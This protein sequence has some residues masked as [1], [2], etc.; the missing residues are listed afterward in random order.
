M[1]TMAILTNGGDTCALNASVEAIRQEACRIGFVSIFGIEGGYHGLLWKNYRKLTAGLEKRRGGSEL[2]SLRESPVK[3]NMVTGKYEIDDGKVARMVE[4]LN[5]LE[6]NV[7]VVIGGDGTLQATKMFH[8]KVQD[9]YKFRI[10]GFPK[11]IDNDIRTKTTFEGIGVSLCPGYPSAARKIAQ[12]TMDIQ[13]T[14]VSA[15]RVFGVETM[16]RDAGWLAAASAD[17]GPDMILIPEFPLNKQAKELLIQ[18]TENRFRKNK[19]VVIVVS[20]GTK[21]ANRKGD[22]VQ[23][24]NTA[25]GPRKLGGVVN[26][27]VKFIDTKLGKKFD[28]ST[29]FGVRPHHTDYLPRSGSPCEYDLKLVAVLAERLRTLLE[30]EKYGKVPVLRT[31]VPYEKLSVEH[32]AALDIDEMEPKPFPERDF[33]DKDR[34]ATNKVFGK[35]LRTITSGPD[36]AR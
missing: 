24:S 34:L 5:E 25:F 22:I 15:R 14:A 1:E 21:W 7:L 12:A 30:K 16:G 10:M 3:L 26:T 6:V 11:T 20:E 17:G 35:F 31:V 9:K 18:R 8:Q 29:P 27:V 36:S 33:Y 19:H 23:I 32:T 2:G 13:T 28:D 4:T